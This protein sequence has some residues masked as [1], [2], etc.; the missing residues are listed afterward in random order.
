[1]APTALKSVNDAASKV[2][3]MLAMAPSGTKTA[4]MWNSKLDMGM[5]CG[6]QYNEQADS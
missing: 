3:T 5:Y 2:L 4:L 6:P 1:M